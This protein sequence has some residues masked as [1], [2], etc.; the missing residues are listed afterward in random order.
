MSMVL[1]A[2][3]AVAKSEIDVVNVDES[4]RFKRHVPRKGLT[5]RKHF[6]F[7]PSER[8]FINSTTSRSQWPLSSR[9]RR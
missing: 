6:P 7:R 8:T 4:K 9:R 2:A 3:R 1:G 5:V